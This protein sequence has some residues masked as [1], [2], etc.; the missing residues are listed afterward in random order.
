MKWAMSWHRLYGQEGWIN[1]KE[2]QRNGSTPE[3][4]NK[5]LSSSETDDGIYFRS[6]GKQKL[7]FFH[8]YIIVQC[9]TIA[10]IQQVVFIRLFQ[11][12]EERR[13]KGKDYRRKV[14]RRQR[15]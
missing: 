12:K 15:Q 14:G 13:R 10:T 1:S 7:R 6:S 2:H 4:W 8:N 3:P 9:G 5:G 11:H